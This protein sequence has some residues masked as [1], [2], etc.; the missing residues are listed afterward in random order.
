[1][2]DTTTAFSRWFPAAPRLT[3]SSPAP[4]II[5]VCIP[6]AGSAESIYTSR[7]AGGASRDPN[8]LKS[9][10]REHGALVLA[11]QLPGREARRH[12]AP[13]PTCR[14]AAAALC[15]VLLPVLQNGPGT[16]TAAGA[17]SQVPF[18]LVAHSVGTWIGYELLLLL[19]DAGVRPPVHAFLSAF[20]APTTSPQDRPWVS[21]TGMPDAQF[22]LECAGWDA[23]AALFSEPT[24]SIY[25]PLLRADYALLDTYEFGA[26]AAEGGGSSASPP[27]PPAS[28]P[29][30]SSSS[31][32][33]FSFSPFSLS[34][35]SS[36]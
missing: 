28:S 12:E 1:M 5:V 19:R 8:A 27:P 20:P 9:W 26:G 31:S 13:L 10:A 32:A 18:T 14:A 4:S 11:A 30:S 16:G 21:T 33:S 6:N 22:K 35:P 34:N 7:R 15:E 3:T 29:S 17:W 23:N 24:W 25:K 36:S 2:T